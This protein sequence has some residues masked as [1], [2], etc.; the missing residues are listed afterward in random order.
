[1]G[2]ISN[3][4]ENLVEITNEALKIIDDVYSNISEQVEKDLIKIEPDLNIPN[5]EMPPTS[6]E[7]N[8]ANNNNTLAESAVIEND[9]VENAIVENVVVENAVVENAIVENDLV[10]ITPVLQDQSNQ[11]EADPVIETVT[12][13]PSAVED[14]KQQLVEEV[15]VET[16][17][18]PTH[19]VEET[20]VVETV[21]ETEVKSTETI[22]EAPQ[23]TQSE[24]EPIN[25]PTTSTSSDQAQAS[26]EE[27]PT[28][29]TNT[30]SSNI[31]RTKKGRIIE[32]P[33]QEPPA[34]ML[35]KLK[36]V[37]NINYTY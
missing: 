10:E 9:V 17:G 31:I 11:P 6:N 7:N 36:K 27:K 4:T 18:E 19:P 26:N 32:L 21:V 23:P 22:I 2:E 15:Q 34:F 5:G 16:I 1:M 30:N 37:T 33:K 25:E 3:D 29:P 8:Q 14:I 12:E 24:P 35:V 28:E 13:T 20:P